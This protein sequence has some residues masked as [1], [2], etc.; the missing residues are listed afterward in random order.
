MVATS[1]PEGVDD[2]VRFLSRTPAQNLVARGYSCHRRSPTGGHNLGETRIVL[3]PRALPDPSRMF[4]RE[5]GTN[6]FDSP[7]Y[8]CL[9]LESLTDHHFACQCS[10]YEESTRKSQQHTM[11]AW[12]CR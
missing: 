4:S 1:L 7:L 10:G 12:S 8:A 3:E 11:H 2:I 6:V 5:S 9:V